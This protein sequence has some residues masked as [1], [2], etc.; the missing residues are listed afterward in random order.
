MYKG[1]IQSIYIDQNKTLRELAQAMTD[2][3]EFSATY[4]KN[5]IP[6]L[7]IILLTPAH[8]KAQ[9]ERWIKRW[10]FTKNLKKE[11]WLEAI[12]EGDREGPKATNQTIYVKGRPIDP[13]KYRKETSRYRPQS[14]SASAYR[15]TV[16][17]PENLHQGT[18]TIA[19]PL[20][21]IDVG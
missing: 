12:S 2:I 3:Y 13:R 10:G 14:A 15:S 17:I 5:L 1:I 11:D 8:R 18:S 4:V 9:Y 7:S 20:I 21:H 16:A 6:L 19:S